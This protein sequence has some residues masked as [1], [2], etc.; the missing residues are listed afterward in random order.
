MKS[1]IKQ[2]LLIT[3]LI[4]VLVSCTFAPTQIATAEFTKTAKPTFTPTI[5]LTYTPSPASTPEIKTYIREDQSP[6]GTWNAVVT[7]TTQGV[8]KNLLFRVSNKLNNQ[9]WTIE[10]IDFT[11][12]ENPLD[13]YKYPYVFK[14]SNDGNNLYFSHLSTGGDGCYIPTKPGGFDMVKFNLTTGDIAPG[15]PFTDTE[16]AGVPVTVTVCSTVDTVIRGRSV[17]LWPTVRTTPSCTKVENP[18]S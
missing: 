13:G 8:N 12:P 7:V 5:T 4:I 15:E 11:E 6:D 18:L 9:I 17:R 1:K 14:W 2:I 10:N 3:V 16:I